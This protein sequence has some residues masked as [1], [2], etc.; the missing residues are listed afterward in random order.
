MVSVLCFVRGCGMGM[1]GDGVVTVVTR[2]VG[3]FV[4]LGFVASI[5]DI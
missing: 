5:M 2:V 1:G 3:G 4:S